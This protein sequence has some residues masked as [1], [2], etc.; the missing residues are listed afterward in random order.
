VSTFTSDEI[1]M[2]AD[3]TPQLDGDLQ[4][5]GDLW[6]THRGEAAIGRITTSGEIT[7][8]AL[9]TSAVPN[10]IA[11]S[12]DG[13]LWFTDSGA[14]VGRISPTGVVT[15]FAL[16]GFNAAPTAVTHGPDG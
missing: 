9:G 10:E 8:F 12:P 16:E 11:G 7:T 14:S 6:F 3:I 1:E 5:T 13:N 15:R 4:P 2:P